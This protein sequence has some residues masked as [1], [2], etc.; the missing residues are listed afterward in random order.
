MFVQII[1]LVQLKLKNFADRVNLGLI[2]SSE[3][4]WPVACAALKSSTG[5]WMHI[6]GNVT[7]YPHLVRGGGPAAAGEA[8]QDGEERMKHGAERNPWEMSGN[9]DP[10]SSPASSRYTD[11]IYNVGA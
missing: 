9:V 10:S 1:R 3:E 8:S 5:G 7:T 2:P 6:H 4:G 11:I